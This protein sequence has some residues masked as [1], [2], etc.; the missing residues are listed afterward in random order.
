M[1][2]TCGGCG[3]VVDGLGAYPFRCPNFA[4]GDVD[5]VLVASPPRTNGSEWPPWPQGRSHGDNP[6]VR[7][8]GL[9]DCYRR[10]LAVGM[11]EARY[12]DIVTDLTKRI[13]A[14]DGKTLGATSLARS[15][16]ISDFYGF[17]PGGGVWVKDETSNVAGSHKVRHLVGI[18]VH[19]LVSEDAGITDRRSRPDLAIASCGNAAVAAGVVAAAARWR[20]KVYVPTH[21][22]AEVMARLAA[23][24]AVVIACERRAGEAG[25]P[26]YRRLLEGL[27]DGDIAFTCQGDL[28]A[29]CLD[30]GRTLGYEAISEAVAAG[31][32][33]DHVV[34]QVGG[35]ALATSCI[36]AFAYAAQAGVIAGMP[37]I[38]TLQPL[39]AHPLSRAFTKLK[40]RAGPSPSA[41]GV[42]ALL[43]EAARHRSR[44]MWPWDEPRSVASGIIDDETYDWVAVVRGMLET[45]GSALVAGEQELVDAHTLAA[46]A[47]FAASAT[48]AAGLAGLAQLVGSGEVAATDKVLVLATGVR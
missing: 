40:D 19:L 46:K 8:R 33:P 14:L 27:G 36:N 23:L 25:D 43:E 16:H 15:S 21:A 42:A 26:T 32:V 31:A 2:M 38:H 4:I 3:T 34:V 13:E 22:D 7:F 5:H 18:M 35:G 39:G 28:N 10:S 12:V 41:E 37:R 24:D 17:S 48:G 44:Y 30:G 45:G 20:L 6:F 1:E 11:T 47:G 9:L 29:L